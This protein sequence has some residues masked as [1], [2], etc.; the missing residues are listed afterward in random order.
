VDLPDGT[1]ATYRYDGL[2]RRIEQTV[3][4]QSTRSVYDQEDVLLEFDGT[5]TL[6][7]RWLHGPG[8]D[9]PLLLDRDLDHTGTLECT[10]QLPVAHP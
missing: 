8:S 9:A 10:L 2:G 1:V 4:G 6:Q 3:N 5:H 7:A